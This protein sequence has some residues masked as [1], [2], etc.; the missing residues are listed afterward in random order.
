MG[1]FVL[2]DNGWAAMRESRVMQC[3]VLMT[4]GLMGPLRA[5]KRIERKV[6]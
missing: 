3:G 4:A 2:R 1:S 5:G 6:S